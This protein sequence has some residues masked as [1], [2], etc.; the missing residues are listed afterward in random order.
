MIGTLLTIFA[1]MIGV[2]LFSILVG[3]IFRPVG[4]IVRWL[5]DQENNE[6][7]WINKNSRW[8]GLVFLSL[9]ALDFI[10][11]IFISPKS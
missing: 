2:A 11:V 1:T 3:K 9:I 7:S 8:I 4:S 5:R 6:N 10:Y